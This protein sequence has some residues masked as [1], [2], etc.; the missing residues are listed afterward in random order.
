MPVAVISGLQFLLAQVRTVGAG[1]GLGLERDD[2]QPVALRGRLDVDVDGGE[3]TDEGL[4]RQR[5][6]GVPQPLDGGAR[7]HAVSVLGN[8]LVS[9]KN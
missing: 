3:A 2:D 6:D 1:A 4:P 9:R 5:V 7:W 8:V